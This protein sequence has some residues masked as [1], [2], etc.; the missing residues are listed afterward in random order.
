VLKAAI[1][2]GVALSLGYSFRVAWIA[3][4]SLAQVGEFSFVLARVGLRQDLLPLDLYQYF[5]ASAIVTM[6]LT[7]LLKSVA[8]WLAD[9]VARLLPKSVGSSRGLKSVSADLRKLEG[10][11][12]IVGY[13]INGRSLAKVLRQVQVPY[14]VVELNPRTVRDEKRLGEPIVYGDASS[15]DILEYAG[16]SRARV[17]VVAVADA[18]SIRRITAQARRLQPGLH[19]IVRTRYLQEMEPLQKLGANEVVPEEFETALEVVSRTLRHLLVPRDVVERFVREARVDGYGLLRAR[20]GVHAG[21]QDGEALLGASAGMEVFRVE[22]GSPI[23]GRTLE[24]SGLRQETGANVL[25][26]QVENDIVCNP[27]RTT[28]LVAGT[29]TV[30]FGTPEQLAAAARC[31]RPQEPHSDSPALRPG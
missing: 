14:V 25:A 3:G 12:I 10:H 9:R 15:P 30:V 6:A 26:L 2:L 11:V 29:I 20:G 13:G 27:P 16:I 17:L 5:L 8:P 31:F 1:A 18:P 7:P 28:R 24:D 23:E 19:I 4:L 22:S 21:L